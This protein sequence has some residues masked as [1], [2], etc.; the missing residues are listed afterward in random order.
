MIDS[1][2]HEQTIKPSATMNDLE[3]CSSTPSSNASLSDSASTNSIEPNETPINKTKRKI[4][5]LENKA[6]KKKSE[7]Q[8]KC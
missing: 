6:R 8:K 3:C 1:C 7:N 5:V 4:F 2:Q